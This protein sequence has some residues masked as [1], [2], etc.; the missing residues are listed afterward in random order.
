MCCWTC[1]ECVVQSIAFQNGRSAQRRLHEC[2]GFE[3]D[4]IERRLLTFVH[5]SKVVVRV[6]TRVR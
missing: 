1:L 5:N 4:W 6:H 3:C 2:A